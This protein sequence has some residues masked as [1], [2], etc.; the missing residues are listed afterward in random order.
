MRDLLRSEA[1]HAWFCDQWRRKVELPFYMDHHEYMEAGL[2][3]FGNFQDLFLMY[4]EEIDPYFP[5]PILE[6]IANR[7]K[8]RSQL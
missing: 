1:L 8:L 2:Q 7:Y 6:A 5:K 3:D 4:A